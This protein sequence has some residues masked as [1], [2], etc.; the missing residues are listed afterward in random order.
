MIDPNNTDNEEDDDFEGFEIEDEAVDIEEVDDTPEEDRD[1]AP[2]P[3]ELVDEL[4]ADDLGEYSEKVKQRLKQLKKVWHDERREKER[5]QREQEE[6]INVAR[7]VLD[8]NRTLKNTLS[9]G[10]TRL[11]DSYKIAAD[12]DMAAARRDYIAAHETG[13]SEGLVAAQERITA[14]ALRTQQLNDYKPS[15]QQP[16]EQ[17]YQPQAAP[18]PQRVDPKTEAWQKR[19]TWWGTDAEMT[20]AALGLHQKLEQQNGKSFV[21]SDEYWRAVDTTMQR[22]FP[23]YFGDAKPAKGDKRRPSTVV[24]PATRSTAS[25][26][27]VLTK[28][29]VALAKK[30]GL[31]PEQYAREAIK[32][33]NNND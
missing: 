14:A 2:M 16:V 23:E 13:D 17:V 12:R 20:A 24:A 28:S 22:R 11:L 10:E 9:V 19:N 7:R 8:E 5:V 25:R 33:E 4:E 27:V 29:Q 30:F 1:R 3:K 26:K 32:L 18:A 31:T 15:L 6:A 21:G